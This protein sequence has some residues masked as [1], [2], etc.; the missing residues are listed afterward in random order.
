MIASLIQAQF[1]TI[2]KNSWEYTEANAARTY[3]FVRENN[4]TDTTINIYMGKRVYW[5][6]K[7]VIDSVSTDTISYIYFQ[8]DTIVDRGDKRQAL[9]RTSI[10]TQDS[11]M[12]VIVKE[13]YKAVGDTAGSVFDVIGKTGDFR[14]ERLV[15]LQYTDA[16]HK[17]K[18]D[19]WVLQNGLYTLNIWLE[20]ITGDP[21]KYG[22]RNQLC[23]MHFQLKEEPPKEWTDKY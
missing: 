7:P 5:V 11:T 9:L 21:T 19:S 20:K 14:Y 16:T 15:W 3:L 1:V 2:P 17:G 12:W 8:V 10:K 6:Y 18:I 22:G 4:L 23:K 13:R